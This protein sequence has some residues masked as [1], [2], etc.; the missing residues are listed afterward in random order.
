MRGVVSRVVERKSPKGKTYWRVGIV[1]D[2]GDEIW[3]TTFEPPSF[4]TGDRIEFVISQGR[5]LSVR[6][7][8]ELKA[9]TRAVLVLAS[10]LAG[11]STPEE[12]LSLAREL[13]GWCREEKDSEVPF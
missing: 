7:S 3:A 11:S 13:E 9:I 1:L 10:V 8:S 5:L 12:I 6:D 2:S 4:S